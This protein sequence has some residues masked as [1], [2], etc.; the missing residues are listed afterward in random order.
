M[1]NIVKSFFTLWKAPV[2]ID[3]KNYVDITSEFSSN[4]VKM[5]ETIKRGIPTKEVRF[6]TVN[7][8]FIPL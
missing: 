8:Q 2:E 6:G 7:G 5:S 4:L 3:T 1:I